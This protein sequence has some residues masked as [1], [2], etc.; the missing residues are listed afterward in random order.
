MKIAYIGI[1]LFYT[2]LDTL[3]RLGCDIVAIFTCEVDNKTEFNK[4]ICK[5][6]YK[7]NIP[8]KMTRITR[9][10]I[11]GLISKGC[12][13]AV[14][15]GYYY[16]IPADTDLPIVNIH[17]SLLPDGRGSWPMAQSILWGHKKS[18]ITIHKVAEGFDTGDILLQQEF[19]IA[20]D[21]THQSF[22]Q[23]ANSFLPEMLDNLVKNFGE[24]YK[25]AK[26]QGSGS[27]WKAPTEQDFTVT[28]DMTVKEADLILRAFFGY[29]WIY[30]AA[31]KS[32][33]IIGGRAVKCENIEG[34]RYPLADGCIKF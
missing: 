1:D 10:D 27:Y 3:D 2:A 24:L 25:N 15:G 8:C 17:P 13:M 21:E 34:E 18:G 5:F 31:E 19:S 16:K 7:N 4:K 23:K 22:M 11:E 12:D 30:K 28:S 29:E 6:A 14:C 9:K 33:V 26:P 32:E 20:E